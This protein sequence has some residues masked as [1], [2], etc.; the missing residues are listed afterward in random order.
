MVE[1]KNHKDNVEFVQLNKK[2]SRIRFVC[3]FCNVLLHKGDC[4]ERYHAIKKYYLLEE[5]YYMDYGIL[6]KYESE[7]DSNR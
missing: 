3:K 5:N 4:F 1:V 7:N 6:Y 2:R